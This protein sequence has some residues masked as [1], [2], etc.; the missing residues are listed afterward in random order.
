MRN[1]T[2]STF[3]PAH[4]LQTLKIPPAI[5]ISTASSMLGYACKMDKIIEKFGAPAE[6]VECGEEAEGLKVFHLRWEG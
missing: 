6:F 4:I 5:A 2:K 1:V 3:D